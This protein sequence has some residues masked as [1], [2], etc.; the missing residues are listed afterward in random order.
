MAPRA[1][2]ERRVGNGELGHHGRGIGGQRSTHL[3]RSSKGSRYLQMTGKKW[4][5][6]PVDPGQLGGLDPGRAQGGTQAPVG[7]N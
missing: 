7:G 4:V 5:R 3:V 2:D 1:R 6:R